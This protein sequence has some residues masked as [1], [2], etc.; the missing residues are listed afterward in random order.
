[1]DKSITFLTRCE[2]S[3]AGLEAQALPLSCN[4]DSIARFVSFVLTCVEFPGHSDG[5]MFGGGKKRIAHTSTEL[6]CVRIGIDP[7]NLAAW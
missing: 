3:A 6:I 4:A 1:M 7:I 5:V 2:P